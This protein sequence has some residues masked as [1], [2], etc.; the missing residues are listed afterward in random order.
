MLI[1]LDRINFLNK[2]IVTQ[3]M[4]KILNSTLYKFLKCVVR[5][6]INDLAIFKRSTT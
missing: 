2:V 6:D 5:I 3:L 1:D 4:K